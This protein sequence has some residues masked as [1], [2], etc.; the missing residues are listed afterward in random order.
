MTGG[1]FCRVFTSS[2]DFA[3]HFVPSFTKNLV[4]GVREIAET[5]SGIRNENFWGTRAEL[6]RGRSISR[7]DFYFTRSLILICAIFS[8]THFFRIPSARFR[9]SWKRGDL[10]DWEV[11]WGL[12]EGLSAVI[13][14]IF[15]THFRVYNCFGLSVFGRTDCAETELAD[16]DFPQTSN[17]PTPVR[18]DLG[19]T[20]IAS[21]FP[22][23]VPITF[24]EN[25]RTKR[26]FLAILGIPTFLAEVWGEGVLKI[27][28]PLCEITEISTYFQ[29]VSGCSPDF[30]FHDYFAIF[31]SHFCGGRIR[32]ILILTRKI[33]LTSASLR[34]LL[35]VKDSNI[36]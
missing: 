21:I 30:L 15:P 27:C 17:P 10:D 20:S 4:S 28:T 35:F 19:I 14:A 2:D 9:A 32:K 8:V 22:T 31:L 36:N 12:C 7:S 25:F 6:F 26:V 24:A 33:C 23:R 11:L 3:T 16:T 13:L 29:L 34:E 1:N 18:S 5:T